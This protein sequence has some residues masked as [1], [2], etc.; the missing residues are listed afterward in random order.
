MLKKYI[1]LYP[2][3]LV[4]DLDL[5]SYQESSARLLQKKNETMMI[6]ELDEV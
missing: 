5:P 1:S 4:T 6:N 2:L 3:V